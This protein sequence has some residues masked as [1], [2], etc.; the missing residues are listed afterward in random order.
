MNPIK[1]SI[2]FPTRERPELL[3]RL[4]NSIALK[5]ANLQSIEVLVAIDED[6]KSYDDEIELRDYQFLKVFRVKRSLNFSRDYYT[7]LFKQSLGK[8][9]IVCNDDCVLETQNWDL[10]IA[11]MLDEYIGDGPNI[12]HGWIEDGL[13]TFRARG[14][15]EYCC[16]PLFGRDGVQA[17]DAIFPARIPT[18]GAD[19]WTKR[20]Y[21]TIGRVIHLPITLRHYCYHNNT[22]PQDQINRRIAENQV[23]FDI[24]PTY[25]EIN[26]L[27]NIMRKAKQG[28]TC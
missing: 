6:D 22:R 9:I 21:D 13:G 18:W 1:F 14:H 24:N 4:L 10:T 19:I 12:V 5:T 28:A 23:P 8:Y 3:S 17:L 16:F 11:P 2:L 26:A 7:Y 25:A 20:I 15:G 27:L